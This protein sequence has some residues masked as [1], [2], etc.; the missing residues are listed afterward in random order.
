[1]VRSPFYVIKEVNVCTIRHVREFVLD[2]GPVRISLMVVY[3]KRSIK[4][5]M[6]REALIR[7]VHCLILLTFYQTMEHSD[8]TF[9]AY[10][11]SDFSE[12]AC[13]L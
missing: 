9:L 12:F 2:T 7:V 10:V 13:Q 3:T 11:L 6:F 8:L 5:I 1:M 4:R